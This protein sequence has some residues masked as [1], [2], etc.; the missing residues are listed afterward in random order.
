MAFFSAM[1]ISILAYY[2]KFN[3]YQS[4]VRFFITNSDAV[5]YK[6][7]VEKSFIDISVEK[8][9]LFRLQSFGYSNQ[10]LEILKDSILAKSVQFNEE[11]NNQVNSENGINY[12]S[13]YYQVNIT[14]LGEMEITSYHLNREFTHFLCH[15]IMHALNQMNNDFLAAFKEDQIEASERQLVLLNGEK[16]EV[17]LEIS[18]LSE[19]LNK[20]DFFSL[21]NFKKELKANKVN[22][23]E[24]EAFINNQ[25]SPERLK[26][27][28][29]YQKVKSLD[30]NI[31][32][33]NRT[34]YNDQWSLEMLNKKQPFI[35]Q[36]KPP[37]SKFS[38]YS[39]MLVLISSFFISLVGII[40]WYA[41]RFRYS[42]YI[43]LIFS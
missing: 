6:S 22:E 40:L 8:R 34:L 1:L 2:I 16:M 25:N 20:L 31:E 19:K 10:L 21:N 30:D 43:K 26:L 5:D 42:K 7:I 41:L 14:E 9:D 15:Q 11:I 35:T 23:D 24:M 12:I 4:Q 38:I 39:L 18:N 13:R 28:M 32:S 27:E 3:K 17:L 33:F 37:R 36:D 29:L